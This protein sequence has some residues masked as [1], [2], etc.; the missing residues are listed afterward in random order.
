MRSRRNANRK[1]LNQRNRLIFLAVIIAAAILIIFGIWNLLST[2][3]SD[4]EDKSGSVTTEEGKNE[5]KPEPEYDY[6][7][8]VAESAQVGDDYFSDAIFVGDS[9]TEGFL[10]Y[11]GL[12]NAVGYAHKGLRADTCFTD[13]VIHLNGS[14]VT[15]MDALRANPNFSK[16]YIMLGTNELGWVYPE[17]FVEGYTKVIDEIRGINPGALIYAESLIPVTSA[18]SASNETV[19]NERIRMYN[20]MIRQIAIDKKVLYLDV[21]AGLSDENGI[22][23]D[24]ASS[25]GVHLN[26]AYCEKW[27]AYLKTH[28]V[29]KEEIDGAE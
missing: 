21:G 18:K 24:E 17:K 27:L 4:P 28:T 2:D 29:T 23:P 1:A 3:D 20:E 7:K 9:R 13:A 25:D 15:V 19:N 14:K 6:S 5:K 22:L 8:A 26:K 11:S 12:S 16:V 10:L